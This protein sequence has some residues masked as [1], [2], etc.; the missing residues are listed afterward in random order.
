MDMSLD[1]QW[2]RERPAEPIVAYHWCWERLHRGR[3]PSIRDVV[4]WSGLSRYRADIVLKAVIADFNTWEGR[5]HEQAPPPKMDRTGSGQAS[6]SGRT[7]VGQADTDDSCI[8]DEHSDSGRTGVGQASD[9]SRAILLSTST[10]STP[11][12]KGEPPSAVADTSPSLTQQAAEVW[13]AGEAQ[14]VASLGGRTGKLT[15][16]RKTALVARMREHSREDV[17]TV[18]RWWLTSSHDRA[19]FLRGHGSTWETILRPGN[20]ATYLDMALAST[21][22]SAGPEPTEE[23]IATY[24]RVRSYVAQNG[25]TALPATGPR[26]TACLAAVGGPERLLEPDNDDI[27]QRWLTAWRT[28]A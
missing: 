2:T 26:V 12:T 25:A 11:P 3:V 5:N 23:A 14:R 17:E 22:S 19:V 18:I 8:V 16:S 13:Q 28:A 21:P 6:D 1:Q 9:S 7:A 20:F 24:E 27:R 10:P 15:R 4:R